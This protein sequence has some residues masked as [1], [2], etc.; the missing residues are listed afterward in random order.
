MEGEKIMR[1]DQVEDKLWIMKIV[2]STKD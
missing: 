1:K 2:I